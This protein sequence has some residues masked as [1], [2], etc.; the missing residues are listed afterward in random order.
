MGTSVEGLAASVAARVEAG[1][2]D[3][4]T[5]LADRKPTLSPL[6]SEYLR[7]RVARGEIKR[8]SSAEVA[9]CLLGFSDSFG[10]RPLE[11]LGPKAIDR[12]LE[13]IGHHA[14]ATR[15]QYLSRVRGFCQWLL[16]TRRITQDPV[17]HVRPI[18]EPRRI[19]RT[20]TEA[21]VAAL[22]AACPNQRAR[23]IV[24]LMVGCGCRCVE[25]ARLKVEDYDDRRRTIILSGKAGHE[26][27][28]PAPDHVACAVRSYLDESGWAAG[29][30]IRNY[31]TGGGL[32]A[33][34][35]SGYMRAWLRDAGVKRAALDGRSAHAL[36]RTA[37]SDVMEQCDDIRIVQAMMGHARIE[38]TAKHY[39]RPVSLDALRDA[40]EGRD[41]TER[42]SA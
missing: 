2:V 41:Y 28:V 3:F 11:Q 8:A 21:E 20:L 39:L 42:A 13:T 7:Q 23:T 17:G 31:L 33:R 10:R 5:V 16:A 34:T 15:R 19:P 27:E 40:M 22:L 36:R 35:I 6:I 12:W 1:H 38:T 14:P 18:P 26:R 29:P 30:L 32:S 25:V 37:A 4:E 24:W 9:Y